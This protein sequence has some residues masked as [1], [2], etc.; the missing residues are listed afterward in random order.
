SHTL[1][2]F[3]FHGVGGEHSINVSR[4]AHSQLIHYL[5]QHKNEIWVA[6]MVEVAKYI[7]KNQSHKK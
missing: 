7:K 6:P 4:E 1:L 2:V 3:L 5:K